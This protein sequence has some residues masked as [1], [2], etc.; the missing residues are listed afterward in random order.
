MTKELALLIQAYALLTDNYR[1]FP[2]QE[3]R[4]RCFQLRREIEKLLNTKTEEVKK[5]EGILA[6]IL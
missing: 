2:R 5:D 4:I 3:E 6:D 1:Y